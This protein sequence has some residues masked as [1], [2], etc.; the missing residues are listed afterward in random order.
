MCRPAQFPKDSNPCKGCYSS[1]QEVT[2]L[3]ACVDLIQYFL[4]RFF[5]RKIAPVGKGGNINI[6]VKIKN[7]EA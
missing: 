6:S 3:K 1:E 7:M 4:P 5:Q 2:S